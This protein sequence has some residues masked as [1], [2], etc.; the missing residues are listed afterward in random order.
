MT[1][2]WVLVTAAGT[3]AAVAAAGAVV[4]RLRH[5]TDDEPSTVA[6]LLLLLV[7]VYR[8]FISPALPPSCRFT[9]SCSAY[10]VEAIMRHGAAGGTWLTVRRLLRCG[11]WHPGG[12]DP[13]PP[14][15]G[16]RSVPERPSSAAPAST[17]PA[18]TVPSTSTGAR[19]C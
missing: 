4:D 2:G 10:A 7:G 5:R 3:A 11:P 12:H 19:P 13:V 17:A 1:A 15:V 14:G 16:R 6:R 9:P 18:A 8:R